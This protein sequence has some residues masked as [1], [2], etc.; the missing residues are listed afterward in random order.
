MIPDDGCQT[1]NLFRDRGYSNI[2]ISK[3]RSPKP[4]N[5][6]TGRLMNNVHC[7]SKLCD[8]ILV[9]K[10]CHIGMRPGMHRNVILIRVERMKKYLRIVDDIDPDEKMRRLQVVRLKEGIQRLR[11]LESN[12]KM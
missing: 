6:P 12:A 7:P 10:C 2:R 1:E 4:G 5:K 3:R 11:W 8:N 9:G